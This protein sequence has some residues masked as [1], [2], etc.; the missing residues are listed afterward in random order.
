[1][2]IQKVHNQ[3]CTRALETA[4]PIK[5]NAHKLSGIPSPTGPSK[6]SWSVYSGYRVAKKVGM[7]F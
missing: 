5:I 6:R 7:N 4:G 2:K 1:M 3:G